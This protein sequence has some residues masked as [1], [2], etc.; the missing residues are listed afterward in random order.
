MTTFA[1]SNSTDKPAWHA[2]F[3]ALL[4]VIHSQLRYAF[5]GLPPETREEAI[6]E[7]LAN[8]AATYARLYEQGKADIAYATPLAKFAVRQYCA[9]R[10]VGG[11]LNRND[12]M[13]HYAQQHH[14]IVVERLDRRDPS[15]A[16]RE[17][18]VEDKTCTPAETA[19]ARI[20]FG[21]WLSRLCRRDRGVATTLAT[22]ET[23]CDTA[24]QFG[25]TAGRVSQLR[26]ELKRNWQ[27]FQGEPLD[28]AGE[29][30]MAGC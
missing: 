30:A 9:G 29:L 2:G 7:S 27:A 8:A 25:L 20:D 1:Q 14:G 18:L 28:E 24:R 11:Q 4:P 23:T 22:G 16:W 21:D 6:Q 13:S 10:R 15:G 26:S 5:R 3:V 19:A 17:V 12:V